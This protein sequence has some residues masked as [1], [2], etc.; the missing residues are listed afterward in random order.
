MANARLSMRTVSRGAGGSAVGAAAYQARKRL[1]LERE[2]MAFNFSWRKGDVSS[3]ALVGADLRTREKLWNEAEW[4]ERQWNGVVAREI[5]V[6]LPHEL[7][8]A[9]RRRL[10][11]QLAKY[12]HELYGVAVDVAIHQPD[13]G[14][15][16]DERN[17]HAHLLFTTR[18][19][20]SQGFGA[21]TRVLDTWPSG[22]EELTAIR[23]E[24]ARM[25][26]VELEQAGREER[27]T[28]LANE[29]LDDGAGVPRIPTVHLGSHYMGLERS[30]IR[31]PPGDHN[32]EVERIN[33]IR[34]VLG[35]DHVHGDPH[36]LTPRTMDQVLADLS[37]MKAYE[38]DLIVLQRAI[39]DK[40]VRITE[41]ELRLLA[42]LRR[43]TGE[44]ARLL[45]G[46]RMELRALEKGLGLERRGLGIGD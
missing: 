29:V 2:E 20:T 28:H 31:T 46:E 12:L 17:H 4:A 37:A 14:G 24:W 27:V 32:R 42:E 21:K 11:M 1:Y 41:K 18:E 3:V 13:R 33:R 16:G 45:E 44:L 30:G 8:S 15:A 36:Q 23:A 40:R 19:V 35:P 25:V 6:A 10:A 9:Q 26:N 22:R 5:I 7:W 43:E 39:K 34:E 38:W